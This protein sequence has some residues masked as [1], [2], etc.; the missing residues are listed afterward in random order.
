VTG[1]RLTPQQAGGPRTRR[2]SEQGPVRSTTARACA[3]WGCSTRP[4]VRDCQDV[5]RVAG[6]TRGGATS[7]RPKPSRHAT[8][9]KARGRVPSGSGRRRRLLQPECNRT[10]Q[11]Q[12]GQDV[13]TAGCRCSKPQLNR[14]A[15]HECGPGETGGCR[16]LICGSGVRIPPGAPPHWRVQTAEVTGSELGTPTS[17]AVRVPQ[18]VGAVYERL[19]LAVAPFRRRFGCRGLVRSFGGSRAVAWHPPS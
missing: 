11:N 14:T 15:R 8:R 3:R 13:I 9:A 7:V 17:F 4:A 10:R 1:R 12:P 6:W 5:A 18:R 16:L 2:A 19:A